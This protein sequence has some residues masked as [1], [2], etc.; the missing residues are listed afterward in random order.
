MYRLN[1]IVMAGARG[2]S[3][4]ARSVGIDNK[5]FIKVAGKYM[6]LYSLD[7][8]RTL[9][10]A[11]KVVVVGPPLE[12]KK[13]QKKGYDF[14][15]AAEKGEMIEN[16]R[17]GIRQ[18]ADYGH[19][20]LVLTSD[21]PL[22]TREGL[23]DFINSALQEGVDFCYPII[24]RHNCESKYPGVSRTYGR[25]AEGFFTGG[26]VFLVNPRVV[27][28]TA[29]KVKEFLALRKRPH[30]LALKL[31]PFLVLKYLLGSLSIRDAEKKISRLLDIEGR[32][33]ISSYPEIGTDVDKV[34]DLDLVERVL[35]V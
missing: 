22:L 16:L 7:A 13:I 2:S 1:A 19:P 11:G 24:D 21:I 18:L 15:I 23:E 34:S 20:V 27:E 6:L 17:E 29:Q 35:K 10:I 32:A 4:L 8:L 5:A 14:Y 31:G 12:L 30:A 9:D 25:L 28:K 3:P 26:N 33:I